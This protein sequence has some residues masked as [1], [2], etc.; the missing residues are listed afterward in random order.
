MFRAVEDGGDVKVVAVKRML[1]SVAKE[2][3]SL[4][5]FEEEAR[6]GSMVRHPNVVQVQRFGV[7]PEGQP[8]LALEYVPG[9]DLWRLVRHLTQTGSRLPLD[10]T[11]FIACELLTG[12]HAVHE[13]G[14]LSGKPLGIVHRDV[15]PSNVLLSREGEVKLS[16]F[17]I[18]V[19]QLREELPLSAEAARAKGKLGYLAPEQTTGEATDRRT[20][21]FSAAVIVAELLIGRPLFTGGSELAVLL[22]IRD[23]RIEPL[24]DMRDKLP[25]GLVDALASALRRDRTERIESALALS[26]SLKPFAGP[27]ESVRAKLAEVVREA[28]RT[29]K[30][31][32]SSQ[33]IV[34]PVFQIEPLPSGET[35]YQ[36]R[37]A[38]ESEAVVLSYAQVVRG[39]ST[40][41][42][43]PEDLAAPEGTPLIAI[44]SSPAL[45]RHVPAGVLTPAT[46]ERLGFD[47][48]SEC[49][50]LEDGGIAAALAW[51]AVRR[52]TGLWLCETGEVRKEIYL[53]NGVPAFVTSN[54]AEELLGE[55]LVTQGVISRGELDMALAVM[56]RFEGRLGDTLAALG[57]VEP[58]HLFRHIAGQVREKLLDVFLW[59]RGT[60]N[61]FLGVP[62]PESA[63]PLDL[64]SWDVLEEGLTRRLD[65][66]LV[67]RRLA[68]RAD[69]RV[70]RK[71]RL[72]VELDEDNLPS[73]LKMI[74]ALLE[75]P[76]AIGDVLE[77]FGGPTAAERYRGE[78]ELM[79]LGY[80]NALDWLDR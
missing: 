78:R 4:E 52:D 33:D 14:D 2:S 25:A 26:D 68:H 35:G 6:I 63:F 72:P 19:A 18:A 24:L 71:E 30:S 66:G 43:G 74:L 65:R 60:A 15:S 12:L 69:D 44:S 62:P 77:M 57:L 48:P 56:P 50:P 80:L 3:R 70:C 51:S 40:G 41:Q 47:E 42:L 9:V 22:A 16:D 37:R 75:V 53:K 7:S 61:L 55:H 46:T 23:C 31:A 17:G 45:S 8:Y 21:L 1:A 10:H 79:L 27:T 59:S 67:P 58:V 11:I 76:H 20:D 54:L 73:S 36:V 5:M 32:P 38:G 49:V 34:T 29:R 28:Q 39:I 64:D 13:A